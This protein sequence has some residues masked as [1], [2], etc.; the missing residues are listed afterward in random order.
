MTRKQVSQ[1]H[2]FKQFTVLYVSNMCDVDLELPPSFKGRPLLWPIPRPATTKSQAPQAP[3]IF[4]PKNIK[5]I[6][7]VRIAP[8]ENGKWI[9]YGNVLHV[10][11]FY[12]TSAQ[13]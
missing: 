11:A 9:L 13:T 2:G 8:K 1:G 7:V 4:K 10:G 6:P 5:Y 3:S 12:G